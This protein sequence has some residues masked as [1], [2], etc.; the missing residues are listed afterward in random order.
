MWIH[1]SIRQRARYVDENILHGATEPDVVGGG[2]ST[3]VRSRHN[4][5]AWSQLRA[6]LELLYRLHLHELDTSSIVCWGGRRSLAT[7]IQRIPPWSRMANLL[8]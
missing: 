3:Y 6:Q 4:L 1:Q 2:R 7:P 5:N 8:E